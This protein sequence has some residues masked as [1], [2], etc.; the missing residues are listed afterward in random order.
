LPDIVL[1]SSIWLRIGLV[2]ACLAGPILW[3][4]VVNWLFTSWQKRNE[5][6]SAEEDEP[7]FPDYQI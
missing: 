5:N 4:I 2:V 1:F 7:V 6:Q 3:G